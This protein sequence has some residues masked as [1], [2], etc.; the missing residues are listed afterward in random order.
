MMNENQNNDFYY[1]G[2]EISST[3]TLHATAEPKF[4]YSLFHLWTN[5]LR[6]FTD[7]FKNG[8][9]KGNEGYVIL[10]YTLHQNDAFEV[11]KIYF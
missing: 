11:E 9:M 4:S 5:L 3:I 7:E 1:S 8:C 2:C 10:H 6:S